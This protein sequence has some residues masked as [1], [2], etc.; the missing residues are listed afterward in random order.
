M[1]ESLPPVVSETSVGTDLLQS[2]QILTDLAVQG[3][4]HDLTVFTVLDILLS[5]EEPVGN[6]V[7]AGVGHDGDHL[8]HLKMKRRVHCSQQNNST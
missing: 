7:L 6:L 8:F 4:G 1:S 3:V 5:V 2:L